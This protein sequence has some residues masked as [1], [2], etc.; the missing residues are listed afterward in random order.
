[1]RVG[2]PGQYDLDKDGVLVASRQKSV[3]GI[4]RDWMGFPLDDAVLDALHRMID[5]HE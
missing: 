3:E 2:G 5:N 1:M 4:A